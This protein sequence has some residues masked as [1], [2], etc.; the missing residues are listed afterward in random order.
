MLRVVASDIPVHRELARRHGN[1]CVIL[2]PPLSSPLAIAEAIR[3]STDGTGFLVPPVP[4]GIPSLEA[5]VDDTLAMYE[6][7]SWGASGTVSGQAAAS[8]AGRR[9]TSLT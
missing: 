2:V 6:R 7:L 1:G 8:L 4:V 5:M 3:E 9:G